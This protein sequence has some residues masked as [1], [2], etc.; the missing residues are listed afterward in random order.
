MRACEQIAHSVRSIATPIVRALDLDLV[1]VECTGQGARTMV[2]VFIDKPNGVNVSDCEQVHISLSH[3]LDVQDP[4]SHMYTLEVSS[5]GLDRPLKR[6]EDYA[7]S[8]GKLV[9]L[10]LTHPIDGQWRVSG[11]LR[12]LNEDGVTLEIFG[13]KQDEMRLLAWDA[14][15]Q[16]RLEVEF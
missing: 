5:P 2:R 4:I 10:K 12:D 7:R 16:A 1:D 14:F 15:S 8:I 3:A 11:R 9:S 6:R 13:S